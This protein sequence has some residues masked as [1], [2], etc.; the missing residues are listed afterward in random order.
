ML[1][2]H[3]FPLGSTGTLPPKR[4]TRN[5]VIAFAK[6]F[7]PQPMHLD[8]SAAAASLL[9]SVAA[10]GWHTC[11]MLMRMIC[12]GFM[13]EAASEGGPGV[14]EV[15]WLKPVLPGDW[16]EATW[17]VTGARVSASHPGR[18][19]VTLFYDVTRR[20]DGD[21]VMTA[22]YVHFIDVGNRDEGTG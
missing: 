9:G 12:D 6:E 21:S 8:A 18:G 11:A 17:T 10:S 20:S 3:D 13:L 16:L 5:E 1:H 15:R 4:V 14:N 7:D 22:E 19:I 2:Y